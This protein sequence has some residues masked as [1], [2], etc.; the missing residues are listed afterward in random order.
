MSRHKTAEEIELDK[1]LALKAHRSQVFLLAF[2]KDTLVRHGVLGRDRQLA[3]LGVLRQTPG[4]DLGNI[5]RVVLRVSAQSH[6]VE[7]QAHL[8][9][10]DCTHSRVNDLNL[11]FVEELECAVFHGRGVSLQHCHQVLGRHLVKSIEHRE[12]C[13]R[14][15]LV[16]GVT[17]RLGVTVNAWDK[18]CREGED[19]HRPHD[20]GFN[21]GLLA[22]LARVLDF[23]LQ[24]LS[25]TVV[26]GRIASSVLY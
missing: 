16:G 15:K 8:A 17:I 20:P 1:L 18:K 11:A 13:I 21:L 9:V 19:L 6:G 22:T 5:G 2:Q 24:S 4:S 3:H 7:R 12:A 10:V 23:V 14:D 26:T 25:A